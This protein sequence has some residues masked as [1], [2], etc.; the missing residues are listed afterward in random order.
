MT[1]DFRPLTRDG[2][3]PGP[4]TI[5]LDIQ[6]GVGQQIPPLIAHKWN[7]S[8]FVPIIKFNDTKKKKKSNM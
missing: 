1:N 6:V 3:K 4:K 8:K 7:T 2:D 5:F